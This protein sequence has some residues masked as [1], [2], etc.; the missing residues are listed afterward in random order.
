MKKTLPILGAVLKSTVVAAAGILFLISTA[1]GT[2]TKP[3][4]PVFQ[5]SLEIFKAVDAVKVDGDLSDRAW[6]SA[7]RADN[8]VERSPGENVEPEVYTEALITYDDDKLYVAFVCHDDPATIR[9]T[10]CQRDQFYGDDAVCLLVDTYGD[11]AWAYEF[12]VNPYGIQKDYLWS[13]IAG[14]DPGYDLI[15]ESA[16]KITDSGY[17]VEMAIPFT[18]MRFPN[19]EVQSWKVDFWR[20]RPR[21]SYKQFSWAAY[22][23]NEQCWAC[24]WGTVDGITNVRPGKGVELLPTVV[25]NQYGQLADMDDPNSA[26]DNSD[27][28]GEFSIGGKYAISSD[29]TVEAAYN[30][31]FSQIESDAAQID[32]NTTIALFYPE[33]RPFFQEGSDIFRTLFNSFYTRMVNDPQFAAKLTGRTQRNSI[34]FMTALDENTPY[35]IPLHES[36]IILN[37]KKSLVNAFRGIRTVGSDSKLGFI[38][39]DRRWTEGGSGS[40]AAV[41]YDIRLSNVYSIDGQWIL[42]HTDEPHDTGLTEGLEGLRFDDGKHTV[43]FDGE[44]YFGHAFITRFLRFSRNWNFGFDYNQVSP[45]YRTQTGYDPTMNYRNADGWQNYTFRFDD[46]ILES[47]RPGFFWQYRWNFN[48]IPKSGQ[49]NLNTTANFRI[50]QSYAG[51]S[52]NRSGERVAGIWFDD[53][54]MLDLDVGSNLTAEIGYDFSVRHGTNVARRLLVKGDETGIFF[55]LDLKPFDR[56]VIEPWVN[57]LRSTNHETG[58]ELYEGYIARSRF[59]YQVNRQFSVRLVVQYNDF[60]ERWEVDPLF[61]YRLS[62]FSV[63][64]IGST[65]DYDNMIEP[66]SEQKS[67]ELSSRQFFMKLSYLFQI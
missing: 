22:D 28:D 19:K 57:Y 58:E 48:G 7:G 36:S 29:L 52:Y 45:S 5:P 12:F 10:M 6:M 61:T 25:G 47:I 11:A 65:Y 32:V 18:S 49:I 2:K 14:E 62:P 37:S 44:S 43:A 31:D 24:Q 3:F 34:G 50:A 38:L 42:S 53:L 13:S 20:N 56:L 63:F 64:Y 30:P 60:A 51:L 4:E 66:T 21:D 59:R 40:I 1:L 55:G 54:W 17:Q 39:T 33:R 35:M 23:R 16:A 15:W 46:G 26:F 8:F 41:D 27:P 67:W 9:A